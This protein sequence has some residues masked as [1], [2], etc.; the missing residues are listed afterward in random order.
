[1]SH[2]YYELKACERQLPGAL[3]VTR[4]AY[5]CGIEGRAYWSP[6][7]GRFVFILRGKAMQREADREWHVQAPALLMQRPGG[8]FLYGADGQWDEL[9]IAYSPAVWA[10]CQSLGLFEPE[11]PAHQVTREA[12]LHAL[13][14]ELLDRL[15]TLEHPRQADVVDRLCELMVLSSTTAVDAIEIGEERDPIDLV[16]EQI[17]KRYAQPLE[18]EELALEHGMSPS[19]LRRR[20]RRRFGNSPMQYLSRVRMTE[21]CRLLM[22]SDEPIAQIANAVGYD[23]PLYFSRM[24]H[25]IVGLSPS[26]HR[27]QH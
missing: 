7:C 27:A 23:D 25:K 21:A 8:A 17:R 22:D 14:S 2:T 12:T 13:A 4:V 3:P 20:W 5:R 10:R 11:C 1:M 16:H 15:E 24:F 19:T 9:S 26:E 6:F 18:I